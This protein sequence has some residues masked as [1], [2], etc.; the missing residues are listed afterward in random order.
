MKIHVRVV[1]ICIEGEKTYKKK[2]NEGVALKCADDGDSSTCSPLHK[3]S[4]DSTR[5]FLSLLL[6]PDK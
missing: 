1:K 4:I 2:T 3:D 6:A 5:S